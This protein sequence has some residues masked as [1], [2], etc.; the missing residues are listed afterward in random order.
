MKVPSTDVESDHSVRNSCGRRWWLSGAP[1]LCHPP[2]QSV[3]ASSTAR[4]DSQRIA[5]YC[6][7]F[8]A[9]A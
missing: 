2:V 1:A 8:W 9:A 7:A 5:E 4:Q 6:A 3:V